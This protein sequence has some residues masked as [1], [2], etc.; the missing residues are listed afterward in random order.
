MKKTTALLFSTPA[1]GLALSAL[2]LAGFA[3]ATGTTEASQTDAPTSSLE[4]I[5]EISAAPAA[6]QADEQAPIAERSVRHV[7]P[8][9]LPDN[10]PDIDL[11]R[12]ERSGVGLVWTW[13]VDEPD[14]APAAPAPTIEF[15]A[16]N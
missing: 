11:K 13:L 3:F 6:S 14:H 12:P 10:N 4:N 15:A 1:Q 5:L 2:L 16:V 9:F 8:V 7:G